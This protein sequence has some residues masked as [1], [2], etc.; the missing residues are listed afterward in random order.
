MDPSLYDRYGQP[1]YTYLWPEQWN[2]QNPLYPLPP[3]ATR[4]PPP[5]KEELEAA[6]Q[7]FG[8]NSVPEIITNNQTTPIAF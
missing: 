1:K 8:P 4:P 7:Q 2:A 3:Y 6:K 5:T